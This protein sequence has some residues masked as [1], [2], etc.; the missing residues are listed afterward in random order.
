[1][2]EVI[3]TEKLTKLY[4][5]AG[6]EVAAL[7][8]VDLTVEAGEFVAVMG[9]SGSGKSS[10]MN[11][12]GC[13]DQPSSGRCWLGGRELS[14]LGSNALTAIRNQE[15]GFVFQSYNLLPRMS[16][17]DNVELPMVYAE[18]RRAERH[19][20]ARDL[21]ARVGLKGREH[22]EPVQLSGGQQQ[23]VAI[24]R[25]LA[26][27]PRLILADEPTG[28]LDTR[29]GL[30]IMAILQDLNRQGIT[31]VIVTHEPEVARFAGRRIRFRDGRLVDD[32]RTLPFDAAEALISQPCELAA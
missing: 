23:R 10:L 12:I 7:R 13:L 15:I 24:A 3:R 8:G 28:A 18:V 29:S 4:R 2:T 9:P 25:A 20:R 16:A 19:R 21:L 31:V 5:M 22:H 26:N 30:E 27:R 11:I 14:R 6:H 1:M 32:R 17:Q